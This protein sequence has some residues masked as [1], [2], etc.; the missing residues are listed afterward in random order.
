MLKSKLKT[1]I[2][3]IGLVP[4]KYLGQNFLA[5]EQIAE[6][7]VDAADLFPGDIVVEVGPGLGM[8][9]EK[10]LNKGAELFV[11]EINRK[12]SAY[13]RKRFAN[14]KHFH[15]IEDDF[16]RLNREKLLPY[17]T[18]RPKKFI[19]NPPYRGAK[20]ILK[21]ITRMNI[22]SVAVFTIQKQIANTLLMQSGN[23]DADSLTYYIN[24]RFIPKKLFDIPPNFFYPTPGVESTTILL[25]AR[26]HLSR[27]PD[28]PFLFRTLDILLKRKRR[29]LR[30]KIKSGFHIP[31]SKIEKILMK[32]SVVSDARPT[33]LSIKQMTEL[34]NLLK[35]GIRTM[36]RV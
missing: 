6:R 26:K 7:I 11:V 21:K 12:L 33:D 34:S 13:L 25:R 23:I 5:S 2:K 29:K 30:N 14:N 3:D 35:L 16:L 15:I 19:S 20:E 8:I 36:D 9:T 24:Y 1:I 4:Q 22:F 28:E 27:I 31:Y 10:I 17:E 18:T 32:I